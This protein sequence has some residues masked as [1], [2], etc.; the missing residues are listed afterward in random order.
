AGG[1]PRQ[2]AYSPHLER[3]ARP[4]VDAAAGRRDAHLRL[5]QARDKLA[6]RGL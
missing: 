3:G 1:R 5:P 4:G 2:P 6:Q